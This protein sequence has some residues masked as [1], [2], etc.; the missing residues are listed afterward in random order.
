MTSREEAA[1]PRHTLTYSLFEHPANSPSPGRLRELHRH[2][3]Q[4]LSSRTRPS[5]QRQQQRCR[6]CR[7]QPARWLHSSSCWR[8]SRRRQRHCSGSLRLWHRLSR[9][10][11]LRRRWCYR[12][13]WLWL[14]LLCRCCWCVW[15][16]FWLRCNRILCCWCFCP[17][18]FRCYRRWS[19]CF[20]RISASAQKFA[21]TRKWLIIDGLGEKPRDHNMLKNGV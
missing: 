2:A 19:L 20:L 17:V 1:S 12:L 3:K 14:R 15:H 16:C 21:M 5:R 4:R 8:P 7:H 18:R 9:Y 13:F 10:H 6:T 11:D